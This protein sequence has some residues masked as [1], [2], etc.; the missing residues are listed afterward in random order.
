MKKPLIT[1]NNNCLATLKD[2]EF[3]ENKLFLQHFK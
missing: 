1:T 2:N 3:V